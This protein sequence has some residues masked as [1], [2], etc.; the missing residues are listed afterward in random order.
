MHKQLYKSTKVV[1][2]AHQK[3]YQVYY[4]TWWYPFWRYD[5][6]YKFDE[7]PGRFVHYCNRKQAEER[8]VDRAKAMLETVEVW[9]QTN[10][11]YFL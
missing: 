1:Y 6:F 7:E 2:D 8:A 5:S 4:K 11:L 10:A 9:K 3:E